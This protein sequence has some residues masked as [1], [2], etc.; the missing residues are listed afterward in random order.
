MKKTFKWLLTGISFFIIFIAARNAFNFFHSNGDIERERQAGIFGYHPFTI[1]SNSMQPSFS[2]GDVVFINENREP[3][4]NQV[5]SYK[6]PNGLVITHRIIE[7]VKRGGKTF[8]KTKGDNNNIDDKIWIPKSSVIGVEE[9]VIPYA[10]YVA[11]F[12]AG[13]IGFFI[14]VLVPILILVITELF[15]RLGLTG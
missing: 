8:Y 12:I 5:I 3:Q 13:P 11:N 6:H 7:K 15:K 14:F 1:L 9:F 10:G 2:A 4:V